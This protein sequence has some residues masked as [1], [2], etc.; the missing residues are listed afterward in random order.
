MTAAA[1]TAES[2][3]RPVWD[4]VRGGWYEVYYL[5]FNL[6]SEQ[7][8]FWIRYTMTAPV[9]EGAVPRGELW[10]I[11]FDEAGGKHRAWKQGFEPGRFS[12][13]GSGVRIGDAAFNHHGA[14]GMVGGPDGLSWNLVFEEGLPAFS[15]FPHDWMYSAP[16]PKTKVV[17]PHLSMKLSGHVVVEGT[18]LQFA[19]I[20]GHQ[21][22]IWG[23]KHAQRWAWANCNQWEGG[24]NAALE[25]LT[26]QVKVGKWLTPPLTVAALLTPERRLAFN[27]LSQWRSN[28]SEY[29]L[30]RWRLQA[31]DGEHRLTSAITCKPE[32][33]AG[34]RYEDPDGEPR[35]CH[36]SKI[37]D[38]EVV[39]ERKTGAAWQ[40]IQ[41]LR[42]TRTA[43]YEVVEPQADPR[44]S[45]LI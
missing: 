17:A 15:H 32:W 21:A 41:R 26:A 22:H 3:N 8:A 11:A 28:Q 16:L 25:L 14:R 1:A 29:G 4:G 6:P 38:C 18:R 33:M 23:T 24:E 20:P 45:V 30:E 9:G 31:E 19:R 7:R 27:R 13:T 10:A 43:A 39:L 40:E 34:V 2:L 44:V 36:N 35:I 42:A 12:F 37:A 5:K